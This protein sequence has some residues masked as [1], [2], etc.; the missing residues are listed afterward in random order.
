MLRDEVSEVLRDRLVRGLLV[1]GARIN[2]TS[3]SRELGVSRTP[4]R[5][6]LLQMEKEGLVVTEPAR[7]FL[8]APLSASE[9][10]EV[11]PVVGALEGLAL[12][13]CA[14]PDVAVLQAATEMVEA[15]SRAE[16]AEQ[17]RQLDNRFHGLLV[18]GCPNR[19]L[20]SMC[21]MLKRVT[22]RYWMLFLA[23]PRPLNSSVVEHHAILQALA[24]GDLDR[25]AQRLE[26]HWRLGMQVLLERLDAPG[27]RP[28]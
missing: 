7:G 20:L 19:R 23:D 11:Y 6:S 18:D 21:D 3:L 28:G 13:L 10:L 27:H 5:E 9:V 2:E 24:G 12:R 8:A 16:D 22:Q 15:L 25:A 4:L 26:E 14:A 1:P 17:A